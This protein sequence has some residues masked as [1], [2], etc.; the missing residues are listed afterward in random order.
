MP[1]ESRENFRLSQPVAG[2][3]RAE[4]EEGENDRKFDAHLVTPHVI[5]S[6]AA[7]GPRALIASQQDW[8]SQ[9]DS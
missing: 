4:R 9:R 5:A 7:T 6:I 2:V 3:A 1:P 8:S